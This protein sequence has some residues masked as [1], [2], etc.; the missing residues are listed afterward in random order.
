M[1]R[2]KKTTQLI[3]E[4]AK[5]YI[6]TVKGNQPRL[7]EQLQSLAEHNPV[8]GRFVDVEKTRDR[9]TCWIVSVFD[10]LNGIDLDWVAF[11][12]LVQVER[13]WYPAF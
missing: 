11:Q 4:A 2:Q 13:A 3:I 5:D 9:V 10:D 12:S 1:H 7:F 8:S 6:V